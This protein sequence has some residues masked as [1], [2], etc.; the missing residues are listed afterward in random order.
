MFLLR[1]AI[2]NVFRKLWRSLITATPV[3]VGVMM[4]L[5]GWGLINGIDQAVMIG[6]IKSDTGHFRILAKGFLDTEEEAKLDHLVEDPHM[7]RGLFPEGLEPRL[8]SRLR[9]RGELSDGRQSLIARGFGI[10]PKTYFAD[11]ALPLEDSRG[12]V[13]QQ[14]TLQTFEES[15]LEPMWIG[16]SLAADFGVQ[17]GDILTV[18][19]RTRY[20]SYTA[21]DF[22]I[23]ALVRSQNPAIDNLTFFIPLAT[24]QRL[25]DCDKA[26]SELVGF[27]P[28]RDDALDLP[29]QMG[30]DLTRG[31]LEIQTWRQR[32]E[33]ILQINRLRRKFLGVLVAIIILVAATGIANTVVMAAFERIREIGTLRALG[34]QGSG[35]VHLFLLEALLIG[36]A[37][38]T[39][40]CGLGILVA[41]MLRDGIDLSAMSEAGGANISMRTT[42]YLELDPI[43]V[44]IAFSIGLGATLLAALYPS[45]KFSRLSPMEAMRR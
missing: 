7:A 44:L 15:G 19:A 38:A 3:L 17:T 22:I 21:E 5:L 2:K 16:A 25:L 31:G 6:Q 9:F 29:M 39:A 13:G 1:L 41:H 24:A 20:G 32:A 12:E 8:H 30:A 42:L 45:I 10:E 14:P 34:L 40:G 35:V 28:S 33:P 36:T 4:T 18:L 26:A 43:H 27:L 37:G 23:A 11:F